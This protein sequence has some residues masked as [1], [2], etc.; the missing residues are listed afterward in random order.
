MTL[1]AA[2]FGFSATTFVT[3]HWLVNLDAAVD[4]LL[5]SAHDSP[6]TKTTTQRVLALSLAYS[7]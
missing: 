4:R 5:G 6:I 1:T 2:G 7:W 3:E